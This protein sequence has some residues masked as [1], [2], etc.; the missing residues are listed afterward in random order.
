M[1]FGKTRD[2]DTGGFCCWLSLKL[3]SLAWQQSHTTDMTDTTPDYFG[4]RE[5]AEESN[6]PPDSLAQLS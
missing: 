2:T 3:Q 6:H 1:G 5:L 4:G